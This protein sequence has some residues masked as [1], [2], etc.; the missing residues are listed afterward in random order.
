M[1]VK[2]N[3]T[4]Y[5]VGIYLKKTIKDLKNSLSKYLFIFGIMILQLV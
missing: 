5:F 4:N 2:E 3:I 1:K